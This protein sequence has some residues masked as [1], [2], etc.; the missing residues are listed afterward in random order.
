MEDGREMW[1]MET[2]TL[3]NGMR[4]KIILKKN[5]KMQRER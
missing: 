2:G 3:E 4:V 1:Q 5:K